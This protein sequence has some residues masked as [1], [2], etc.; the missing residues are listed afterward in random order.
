MCFSV[1]QKQFL[2]C[3]ETTVSLCGNHTVSLCGNHTV[4]LCGNHTELC[5]RRR[6]GGRANSDSTGVPPPTQKLLS[7]CWGQPLRACYTGPLCDCHTRTLCD[8]HTRT[9]CDCHTR[10][11]L[12][13]CNT[14]IVS[15][16]QRSTLFWG[17]NK[18]KIKNGLKWVAEPPF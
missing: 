10:T 9:L 16:Y 13:L 11:L 15:V 12:S 8:C 3:T 4:S 6:A 2:C 1:K 7:P 14:E 17:K 5:G 18:P